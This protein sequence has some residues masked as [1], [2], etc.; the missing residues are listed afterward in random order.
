MTQVLE[1]LKAFPPNDDVIS[2]ISSKDS[3]IEDVLPSSAPC[4]ALYSMYTYEMCLEISLQN[5]RNIYE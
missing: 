3:Q 2:M 1:F 4:K 5:V